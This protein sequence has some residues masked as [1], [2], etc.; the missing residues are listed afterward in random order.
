MSKRRKLLP[1][2]A[3]SMASL[4]PATDAPS[5][6]AQDQNNVRLVLQITVDGLRRDLLDRYGQRFSQGGFRYL[7]ESG[8]F[9]ANAH[10]QHAN[11]E[12]IVGHA[13]LATGTFPSDHGMIGNVWFDS[14]LGELGYNIEDPKHPLLPTR[15]N[16]LEGEQVDPA[17]KLSRTKGRSPTSILVETFS[18]RLK[19]YYGGH[20]KV[21][22]VSAK[23]RG[24]VSMAGHTGK[25]FWFSTDSGDFVSST[26]YYDKYPDWVTD[27][28]KQ[29]QVESLGGQQWQL[30]NDLPTYL[31]GHQDNRPYETDLRGYGRVFPHQFAEAGSPILP[32]QVIVSPNGDQLTLDFAKL[33]LRSEGLGSDSIPDYLGISF[34]GLDA[35]NHF[36][37]PSSLENEDMMLQLDRTLGDLLAF[38]DA[39]VGLNKTLIVLSADHGMAEMPEYMTEL[40][41]PA[42]RLYPDR[43]IAAANQIAK[44]RFDIEDI[45]R[46]YYRPYLYLDAGK[47]D[48]AGLEADRIQS[49]IAAALTESPGIALAVAR[50]ELTGPQATPLRLQV[51]RNFHPERSG[52]IYV[53]QDL[54]W[55]NFD[56]GPVAAMHGSPWRYDT[57]VPIIFAGAGISSR[58]VHRLVHPVDVAPTL[59][60]LLGM[61][62]PGSAKGTILGEALGDDD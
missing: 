37:G 53:V 57:H 32:T 44:Q 62:A 50:G 6:D 12:T 39:T 2:L 14:E 22:A 8:V 49:E 54:Y 9:F 59:S 20:S 26:Y 34:S 19:A 46:F 24:A 21:F 45:V 15:K 28:N 3:V 7:L 27:W 11:T 58:V 5:A 17:Q 25:A 13:T 47:I 51:Q 35:V 41:F 36:F 31:L 4:F 55:F 43:V 40:G 56:K 60:A 10:Y 30:L 33:L 23:D 48:S 52:D 61:T 1:A 42:G 29:R 16:A 38:I 18:D